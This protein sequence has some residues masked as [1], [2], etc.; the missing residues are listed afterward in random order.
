MALLTLVQSGLILDSGL[1]GASIVDTINCDTKKGEIS[2]GLAS[3]CLANANKSS[4]Q[5]AGR[6]NYAMTCNI[7]QAYWLTVK[8]F[9]K[10]RGKLRANLQ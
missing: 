3:T 10:S 1:D 8:H 4:C 7:Q 2:L 5:G 9:R 6:R